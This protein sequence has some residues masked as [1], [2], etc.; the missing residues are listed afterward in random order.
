[1]PS[2][3]VK[4]ICIEHCWT[5]TREF[6]SSLTKPRANTCFLSGFSYASPAGRKR[7]ACCTT[8]WP[9]ARTPPAVKD[10]HD[11]AVHQSKDK[12]GQGKFNLCV[13]L[14]M[15]I[16]MQSISFFSHESSWAGMAS[17]RKFLA[18]ESSWPFQLL[19][20]RNPYHPLPV[21]PQSIR[22]ILF[23]TCSI[24][25]LEPSIQH[26]IMALQ[27]AIICY[28][29]RNFI[30]KSKRTCSR[31]TTSH[32]NTLDCQNSPSSRLRS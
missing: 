29:V 1:M 23:S 31:A 19:C 2:N 27:Y 16:L 11:K 30:S 32:L 18:F 6:A 12:D 8:G 15:R 28:K 22:S 14:S 10:G 3:I 5:W 21:L 4:S 24:R 25:R 13:W 20:C 26:T 17:C 7:S 9:C